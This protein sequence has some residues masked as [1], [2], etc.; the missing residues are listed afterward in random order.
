M[1]FLHFKNTLTPAT[2][3]TTRR[4]RDKTPIKEEKES[5]PRPTTTK[6]NGNEPNEPSTSSSVRRPSYENEPSA[7]RR[8]SRGLEILGIGATSTRS[9]SP[10]RRSPNPTMSRT[11]SPAPD[12][13]NYKYWM[14]V[15]WT[16]EV[17]ENLNKAFG[18]F[19]CVMKSTVSDNE[20]ST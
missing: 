10:R 16:P 9:K 19:F 8:N 2:T 3:P 4:K 18:Y 6:V 13:R 7:R 12:A 20:I 1:L 17:F 11:R 14:M 5:S 15:D